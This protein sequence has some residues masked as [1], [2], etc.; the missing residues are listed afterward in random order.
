M[1]TEL[2][3]KSARQEIDKWIAKYP[4][5][6][7]QSAVLPA[8]HIVQDGNEGWLPR[9]MLDSVADYLEMPRIAVYEVATFYS[10]FDL[11]KVGANKIN[12]CTNVS[13]QLRGSEQVVEQFENRL[14]VK[15]GE[16]TDDGKF[17]LREVECLG[18]CTNA[19]M[20]QINK[21]Y[22]ENLTPEKVDEILE[23]LK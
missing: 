3:S 1:T 23:E 16:T 6:Q 19:P 12:V 9:E 4:K 20:C 2:L 21:T 11:E 17:T 22:Y 13:C 10:M 5:E 18:A 14:G 15:L 8:L 7:R